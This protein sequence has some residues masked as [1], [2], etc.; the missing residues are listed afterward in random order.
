MGV[1]NVTPDSFSEGGRFSDVDAAI[2]H[3]H[4][5][6][7][8]GAAVIDIGGESTRPGSLPVPAA[9]QIRRIAPV[10]RSLAGSMPAVISADTRQSEVARAALDAGAT[11]VNDISAGRDDAAL[12][13]LAARYAAPVILMHMLGQP[14]TM[15]A[16]PR[17]EDVTAEVIE[18]LRERIDVAMAAGIARES[19]LIDPGIGFGKTASDNLRLLRE[20]GRFASLECP[21]AV[22]TSRKGFVGRIT[23][24]SLESRRL[25]GTAATVAWTVA[26]GARLVRVHDVGPMSQVVR[27]IEA[28]K[29]VEAAGNPPI[30]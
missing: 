27:M 16:D 6:A 10:I 8:A 28:I 17:Y 22:G 7:G 15:Q 2:A 3:G 1:L 20:L 30:L 24:E 23:G 12:L 18:F 21:L 4:E 11:I 14:A 13:P 29:G 9:E 5:M 25:F 26:N 19:I